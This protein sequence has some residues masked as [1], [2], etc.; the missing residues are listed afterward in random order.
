MEQGDIEEGDC[1]KV[2]QAMINEIYC[3]YGRAEV[4]IGR[5]RGCLA[6]KMCEEL[7]Y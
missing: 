2:R 5:A 4:S 7:P 3:S 1:F 6:T